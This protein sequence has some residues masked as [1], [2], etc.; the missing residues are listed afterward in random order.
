[1]QVAKT[2]HGRGRVLPARWLGRAGPVHLTH[3]P[4]AK[5]RD[6][7]PLSMKSTFPSIT[8]PCIFDKV[9]NCENEIRL[10]LKP[11]FHIGIE[12]N[13]QFWGLLSIYIY[14]ISV[15]IEGKILWRPFVISCVNASKCILYLFIIF[16]IQRLLETWGHSIE[17]VHRDLVTHEAG[18]VGRERPVEED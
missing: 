13:N 11:S 15:Q 7:F 3:L 12:M 2:P 4:A 10:C 18:R 1:M 8:K 5:G 9:C 14:L 17:S 16:R 6:Q